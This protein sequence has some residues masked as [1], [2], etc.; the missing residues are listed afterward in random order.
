MELTLLSFHTSYNE[1]GYINLHNL[2]TRPLPCRFPLL[3]LSMDNICLS[4]FG[5]LPALTNVCVAGVGVWGWFSRWT[6]N[7]SGCSCGDPMGRQW[8]WV[9]LTGW[10]EGVFYQ[11]L[12]GSTRRLLVECVDPP[13]KKHTFMERK[14]TS[15][16]PR[17][18]SLCC[19][20]SSIDDEIE[21]INPRWFYCIGLEYMFVVHKYTHI[22]GVYT[23]TP[24][25]THAVINA[26]K[27]DSI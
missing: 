9:R 4:S 17:T 12:S 2:L 7:R 8:A 11:V 5:I 6:A 15:T 21:T 27:L 20:C 14:Q 3:C 16:L 26:F 23:E 22:I 13:G 24:T 1:T 10:A 19:S 25:T 18:H